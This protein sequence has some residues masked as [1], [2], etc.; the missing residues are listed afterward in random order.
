M[1]AGQ[2]EM[3][4]RKMGVEESILG[5]GD[6]GNVAGQADCTPYGH[7]QLLQQVTCCVT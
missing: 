5:V 2:G 3:E 1:A 7:G 4:G 6:P